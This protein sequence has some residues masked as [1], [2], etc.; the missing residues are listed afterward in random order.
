MRCPQC[1]N[2]VSPSASR[3]LACNRT[4]GSGVATV[5]LTPLPDAETVFLPPARDEQQSTQR[6]R[7][8]S[9]DDATRLAGFESPPTQRGIGEAD[10]W[11][12]DDSF[13]RLGDDDP[14][15][16]RLLTPPGT[17]P[18]GKS[19]TS[20][21][22][23]T[24]DSGPLKNGQAFGARYHIIR[25][26]GIGG[27]GAVYQ[28]WDAELGVVVAIKVIRPEAMADPGAA[29]E[30]ER[31][32]KRELLLARQ[33]THK[34]VVRIHDLGEVGG[35]KYITMPYVDGA[36]LA[37]IAEAG[38]LPIAKVLRIARAVTSG[39]V[40]AHAA[41]VVHRDLKPAN[42]MVDA[43][44]EAMIMD[45]GIARST[46]GAAREAT[47][48]ES[49]P[50]QVKRSMPAFADATT[51]GAVVGTV[52]YMAPEQ[53]KGQSADQRVDI[54]AFGLILYDLLLGRRRAEH[55]VS[56]IAELQ[57]R[58]EKAPPPPRSIVPDIPEAVDRIVT[59]CIEPDP[60]K[61]YQTT[62][63][64]EAE[65]NRLDDEGKPLRI[66]RRLTKRMMALAA[67]AVSVALV[68]TW[69][70]SRTA[71]APVQPDP[72][73]VLIADFDNQTQDRAF[74]G[75][76]EQAL[77]IGIEGA[78][79]VTAYQRPAA[80]RLANQ[81]EPGSKLNESVAR[82]V[83]MREAI[84]VVLAGSITPKGSG[85][86]IAVRALNPADGKVLATE[87]ESASSKA[88]VLT[89]VG[90]LAADL[91]DALGDTSS[92]ADRATAKET[93]TAASLDAVREYSVAQDLGLAGKD[94]EAIA[95]YKQAIAYDE[96][97]GRAYSGWAVTAYRM[98]RRDESESAYKTALSLIDRMTEREKFRT[99]GTYY[100][101]IARDYA[102]AID[103]YKDLLKQYP[104]DGSGHNNLA[105][106]YFLTLDFSNASEQERQALRVFPKSVIYRTNLALFAM[107]AGDFE[108]ANKEARSVVEQQ[109]TVH[110]AY[111]PQA[112]AA[113]AGSDAAGAVDAYTRMKAA[114]PRGVSL[115]SLG[116]ADLAMYQGRFSD[117]EV[118]LRAGIADDEK[119]KNL[120]GLAAKY[121]ALAETL[122]AEGKDRLAV[123]MSEKALAVSR[124]DPILIAAAE[125]M[126][127][128][129]RL[130]AAHAIA[131]E[132]SAKLPPQA[133]AYSS[134]IEGE[135]ALKEKRLAQA[136]EA[137]QAP[138]KL[139]DV[140][141]GRF[142]LGVA[143]I[144]AGHY[145][146]AV[147]ELDRCVKRRGEATAIFLDDMPSFRRLAPV[148]YYRGRAQEGLSMK[149]RAI[150][151][152][153][154]YLALRPDAAHDP[155]AADARKRVGAR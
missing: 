125:V 49:M 16:T 46:G 15:S 38:R 58:M 103:N 19:D 62:V 69:Y 150:E 57:G 124:A 74:D 55:A 117:A 153:N 142:M 43:D 100:V 122:L 151:N 126:V 41:G 2:A 148:L 136:I 132:L 138:Q 101:Y 152:Y 51:F 134:I 63:E 118:Q 78:S 94:E 82:L 102:K 39:L 25:L 95:H 109:A 27:M 37:T 3:C 144:E 123:E 14:A 66:A 73:S 119:N 20:P 81:I 35:I 40:A 72:M 10:A 131:T 22:L 137:F 60:A 42:I 149:P 45:F 140:W 115:A 24:S 89:A 8:S 111:L 120:D 54:Y 104:A 121:V 86:R 21:R 70:L 87:T 93:F 146:E 47:Q 99:L 4:L 17:R 91:R 9:D 75:A 106:A 98:G 114:G 127:R 31:R 33:V 85:Y 129:N 11:S 145:A 13:T 79:F 80:L 76:L 64:L 105:N 147:S 141:L 84:N 116:I 110:K 53:A 96:K 59:R 32:F 128:A 56:S 68:G 29:A 52:A 130:P 90:K 92:D 154:A 77:A 133:R 7:V 107:Y 88:N 83:S 112:M 28:A 108:T 61:R 97:F 5:G 135:I 1:G 71:V 6:A 34:N 44:D 113:L 155:N 23:G 36:D 30:I 26:L 143:Y 65:L 48:W 12:D 50:S 67:A 18:P 139:A